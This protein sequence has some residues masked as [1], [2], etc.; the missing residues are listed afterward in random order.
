MHTIGT[1]ARH[2]TL[3]YGRK[4]NIS[5]IKAFD[6]T[7]KIVKYVKGFQ[8]DR[9]AGIKALNFTSNS[10]DM[11]APLADL[12]LLGYGVLLTPMLGLTESDLTINAEDIQHLLKKNQTKY[13]KSAFFYFYRGQHL[14]SQ[15]RLDECMRNQQ[16]AF[17]NAKENPDIQLI[18]VEEMGWLSLIDSNYARAFE[19]FNMILGRTKWYKSLYAYL[20]AVISGSVGDFAK[21][22]EFIKEAHKLAQASLKKRKNFQIEDFGLKRIEYFKKNSIKSKEICQFMVVELLYLWVC[23]PCCEE[24]QLNK[25]LESET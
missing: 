24:K 17:E 1:V 16:E 6:G 5:T 21:A 11:R 8:A 23:Y 4:V 20:C 10:K 25:F 15:K 2:G 9:N 3:R 12:I 7:S 22:N 18:S 19:H 13:P 14:R